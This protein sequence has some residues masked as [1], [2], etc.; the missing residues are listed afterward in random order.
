MPST[1]RRSKA[2]AIMGYCRG[3]IVNPNIAPV[4]HWMQSPSQSA[5]QTVSVSQKKKPQ[6]ELVWVR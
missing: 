2:I 1:V 5:D 6:W 3:Y 4:C